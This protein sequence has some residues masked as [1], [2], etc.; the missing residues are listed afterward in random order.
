[1]GKIGKTTFTGASGDE[2]EFEVFSPDT[3]WGKDKVVYIF[4]EDQGD[5]EYAPIY[6]GQTRNMAERWERHQYD[7]TDGKWPCAE[8]SGAD[9]VCLLDAPDTGFR[10]GT[11]ADLIDNYDTECNEED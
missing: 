10:W 1:M 7:S 6:I 5:G 4:A 11:E 9:C 3:E 8:E 2:Y